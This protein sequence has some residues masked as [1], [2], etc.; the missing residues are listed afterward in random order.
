MEKAVLTARSLALKYR[1]GL[2]SEVA[3]QEA[4]AQVLSNAARTGQVHSAYLFYG[5]RGSGKTSMARILAR[6]LNCADRLKKEKDFKGE[7]C[8]ACPSCQDIALGR[9]LDVLEID[10]ASHT[11]V[12]NVREVI[13]DTI[14][15]APVRDPYRVFIIDEV[16]M[17]SAS[18]FNAMLKTLEEPPPN[19]IFV[20]ATT[21]FGKVP[22]TVVSRTHSFMFRPLSRALIEERLRLI[23]EK[24]GIRIEGEAL[25]EIALT[26]GGSLRDA[27]GLLEQSASLAPDRAAPI[28]YE[29]VV[30]LLGLGETKILE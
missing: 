8:G 16:H 3:G 20:L 13:L 27:I 23:A 30:R 18:A 24:E 14:N 25:K 22:A 5:C 7:P 17:L 21:E 2:F 1:P 4:A 26:A 9:S 12:D 6:A 15:L 10:A 28:Q 29:D 11:G 19:V